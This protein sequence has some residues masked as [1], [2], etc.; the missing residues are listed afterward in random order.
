MLRR[1]EQLEPL[2]LRVA[3]LGGG[4]DGEPLGI[5]GLLVVDHDGGGFAAAELVIGEGEAGGRRLQLGENKDQR[6]LQRIGPA[7]IT[8]GQIAEV[9]GL[10]LAVGGRCREQTGPAASGA[11]S[12]TAAEAVIGVSENR[13]GGESGWNE[14]C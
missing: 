3:Q 8:T 5:E 10:L 12:M 4:F 13:H 7:G 6:L 2:P 1:L 11:A 14:R 9:L